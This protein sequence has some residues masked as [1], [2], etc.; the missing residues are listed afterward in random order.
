[1]SDTRTRT[2]PA[3]VVS[4]TDIPEDPEDRAVIDRILDGVTA[5]LLLGSDDA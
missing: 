5:V 3:A 2:R 4:M 1:M